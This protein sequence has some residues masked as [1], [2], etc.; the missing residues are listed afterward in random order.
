MENYFDKQFE[1]MHFEMN[2]FG[3]A[4]PTIMLALLEEAAAEH[5]YSI[6]YGLY[7]LIKQNIGW[8]LVSGV[9][10]ME[11]YPRY[12]EKITIRTWLS[13]YSTVRGFRENTIFDEQGNVIGRARG[14]WMFFD[15][16]R[17]RPVP[18]FE[19]IRSKWLFAN[20]EAI[21]HSITTKIDPIHVAQFSKDI[22]VKQSEI[23][24]YLHANN[25]RYLQW[26]LDSIPEEVIDT[27]YMQFLDGR[28]IS[29]IQYG[30]EVLMLTEKDNSENCFKHTIKIKNTDRICAIATT[31]WKARG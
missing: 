26:L 30:D 22:Q 16:V 25:L 13:A 20:E 1:L 11:R 31:K 8:V 12:K 17:R 4:S 10:E 9:V 14:L 24:M 6:N 5:C 27:H 21:E 3:E 2:K 15:I 19:D 29:E 23:D 18:I 28:F 7:D